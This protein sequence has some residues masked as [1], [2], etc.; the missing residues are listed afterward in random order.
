MK[1]ITVTLARYRQSTELEVAGNPQASSVKPPPRPAENW[2]VSQVTRPMVVWAVLSGLLIFGFLLM[3]AQ[4]MAS[5]LTFT[6]VSLGSVLLVVHS[7]ATRPLFARW[8]W[9]WLAVGMA[10]WAFAEFARRLNL[11]ADLTTSTPSVYDLLHLAAYIPMIVAA[12]LFIRLRRG[13]GDATKVTD[14]L[15]VLV[16][17]ALMITLTVLNRIMTNPVFGPNEVSVLAA[18]AILDVLLV[19]VV[20]RLWFAS[21]NTTNRGIRILA[22]AFLSLL[23]SDV[24][25]GY[26][27]AKTHEVSLLTA[28]HTGTDALYLLFFALAGLAAI[29]PLSEDEPPGETAAIGNGRGRV[30]ALL[31][32]CMLAPPLMLLSFDLELSTYETFLL[33][34]LTGLLTVLITLRISLL[35][36]DYRTLVS[37]GSTLLSISQELGG[38]GDEEQ[39]AARVP[40]W[41]SSLAGSSPSHVLEGH[42]ENG[43]LANDAELPNPALVEE[44][45]LPVKADAAL[46]VDSLHPMDPPLHT[47][48]EA[49]AQNVGM[50]LERLELG[51]QLMEE[52]AALRVESLL[53]QSLDVVAVVAETG[54]IQYVTPAIAALTG[55]EREALVG[56]PWRTLFSERDAADGLL[57]RA[58]ESGTGKGPLTT[59]DGTGRVKHIDVLARWLPEQG[60]YV[61]THH[62][63]TERHD[64]QEALRQQ[65]FHDA[66]TGLSNR[67]VFRDQLARAILRSR[68]S[69]MDFAVMMIDLDDFKHVND[70]LGHPAGDE[71]LRTVAR[72]L[73]ECLRE[74]DTAARL[75]GDEF[76]VILDNTWAASDAG[77]VAARILAAI[78]AP[79]MLGTTEVAVGA[80]IGVAIGNAN[81]HDAEELERNADLALYQA[82]YSGKD[83]YQLYEPGL[84][85][86]AVHRLAMTTELRKALEGDEIAV[87]YQ[88]IVD[89]ATGGIAGVEALARWHHP[90]RGLLAPADFIGIAESSGLIARL[91]AR[92][93]EQAFEQSARWQREHPTH[94]EL[95][96]SV[97]VSGRQLTRDTFVAEVAQLLARSE[98]DPASVL[99]EIT[100]SVLLPGEGVAYERLAELHDLGVRVY[101]D[102]WGTGWSSLRHLD[103]LPVSGLKLAGEFVADLSGERH[104]GLAKAVLDLSNSLGLESVIAE[105][106]EVPEQL[107]V[108]RRLG[109]QLCQG[110]LTGTPQDAD[111]TGALLATTA[112]AT[113]PQAPARA[114]IAVPPGGSAG[115]A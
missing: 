42:L 22:A 103:S 107:A 12:V 99:L 39:V 34:G 71:L 37:R 94:S 69:P 35:L 84:H 50:T 72:R 27:A 97:N 46:V 26:L 18:A 21:R 61:V 24:I 23:V 89:V 1:V 77:Q 101:I 7:A 90:T 109:Y 51:R 54:R 41:V 87:A 17:G 16:V 47:T 96:M 76:A 65:A 56:T 67:V 10:L 83:R 58:R 75:G 63:V 29:D 57:A 55:L 44:L 49:L 38:A 9:V 60:G 114:S 70:S 106:V 45:R 86:D 110:Y 64:L 88:P 33:L 15:I 28:T 14:T 68:R 73:T 59:G 11:A 13:R 4:G 52:H 80:S 79:I 105:G 112:A 100:E 95:R 2:Q 115:Q 92:V 31:V 91:G 43:S 111:E 6:A 82:K 20:V 93:M 85:A 108:L 113:W 74:G 8:A 48:M 62:D 78:S 66:L 30:L 98:L 3:P 25:C 104:S 32:L 5:A 53:A 81:T 40:E 36:L 102:D 19:S